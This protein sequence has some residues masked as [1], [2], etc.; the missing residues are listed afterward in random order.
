MGSPMKKLDFGSADK[1]NTPLNADASIFEEGKIQK[2][3]VEKVAQNVTYTP[4]ADGAIVV[5]G[6]K[7]YPEAAKKEELAVTVAPT[8]RP[9]EADEPL[10]QENPQRFVLFPIKYHEVSRVRHALSR[11]VLLNMTD[12][13]RSGKCTRRLKLPSGPRK[14]LIS[15]R[16]YTT[17]ITDSTTMSDTSF[18]TSLHSSPPLMVS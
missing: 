14:K 18:P 15:L 4:L 8:L 16:I 9:E 3:V 1:E 12:P 17:G 11:K 5:N 6:V 13:T 10:L 2:P 7:Y